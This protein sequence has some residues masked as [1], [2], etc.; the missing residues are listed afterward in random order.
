MAAQVAASAEPQQQ[1]PL[2]APPLLENSRTVMDPAAVN[3]K[4]SGGWR[5][6]PQDHFDGTGP[7]IIDVPAAGCWRLTFSW[8]GR[9]DTLD[10]NYLAPN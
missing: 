5:T 8:S 2:G 3:A 4:G 1:D 9:R 10:L 7:S 6:Y